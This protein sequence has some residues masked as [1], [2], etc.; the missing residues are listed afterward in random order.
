MKAETERLVRSI[1]GFFHVYLPRQK[2]FSENTINSYRTAFNLF[3]DYMRDKHQLP[4]YKMSMNDLNR[5]NL[6]G[7]V[8]WLTTERKNSP[9]TCNQRLM[10]FRSFSKYLGIS[11]FTFASVYADISS[12]PTKK[13]ESKVVEF[14]TEE[15]LK[16]LLEQPDTSK[17]I[18]VR[19]QCLMCLMYDTAARCQELLELK[20]KDLSISGDAPFVYLTGKGNKTRA[21]PLM[22]PTVEHIQNYLK[23]FHPNEA[24]SSEEYLFYT[25]SHGEHHQMSKDTVQLFMKNYGKAAREHCP[26]IPQQVHPHQLRHTRAIH[27]YRGGMPLFILS[28][29]MGHASEETTR[30]YAYADTEM[31]RKA[32]EKATQQTATNVEPPIWDENDEDILRRL[33]GLC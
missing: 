26:D 8:N 25:I 12:V 16:I 17:R 33:A 7:Y 29:F 21:V 18:G 19:N 2:C 31:K 22:K 15:A 3:L 10:A 5:T 9:G 28:E 11:D 30:V 24:A 6:I 23:L 13:T 14:L 4:L 27:L 32:I 20:I 1:H